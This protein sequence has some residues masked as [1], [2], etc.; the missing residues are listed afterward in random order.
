MKTAKIDVKAIKFN[1]DLLKEWLDD[2]D[3]HTVYKPGYFLDIGFPKSIVKA[4]TQQQGGGDSYMGK[5][6]DP[7]GREI[8]PVAV[9]GLTLLRMLASHYD[10]SSNKMGRGSEAR[11]LGDKLIVAMKL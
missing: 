11:E 2:G 5:V 7:S 9:Y 4:H 8:F 1:K 10:V 6:F 3:G